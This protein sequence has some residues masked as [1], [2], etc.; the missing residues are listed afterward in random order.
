[1]NWISLQDE[2][3]VREIKEKSNIRPQVIY[4][5]SVR[6]GVSSVVKSRLEKAKLPSDI[7]YYFLDIIHNRSISNKIAEEFMVYHES[8]QVLV[9]RNGECVYDE[10]HM[11]ITAQEIEAQAM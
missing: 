10:S 8:P 6:C 2:H 1:M 7:D 3:Q 9:I 5:H 11:G 4:K